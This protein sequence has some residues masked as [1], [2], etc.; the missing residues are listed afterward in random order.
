M[1]WH[2]GLHIRHLTGPYT[3]SPS[4]LKPYSSL[5]VLVL[6]RKREV[7][8]ACASPLL[9]IDILQRSQATQL[10]HHQRASIISCHLTSYS[11]FPLPDW[12]LISPSHYTCLFEVS[13]SASHLGQFPR[14]SPTSSNL[15]S[16][17]EIHPTSH[18]QRIH[19]WTVPTIP[20]QTLHTARILES[21]T[22]SVQERRDLRKKKIKVV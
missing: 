8:I 5:L 4:E 22:Q 17:Q 18:I 10:S 3:T 13:K 20:V 12:S 14:P 19:I 15:S 7:H 16:L 2:A 9:Q 6:H 21:S 11:R 1:L